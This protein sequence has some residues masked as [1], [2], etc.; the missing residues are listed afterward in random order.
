MRKG[1]TISG[2][3]CP[4]KNMM[5]YAKRT[6]VRRQRD[7]TLS[8]ADLA[9]QTIERVRDRKQSQLSKE[10]SATLEELLSADTSYTAPSGSVEAY[11][12]PSLELGGACCM[13]HAHRLPSFD[14]TSSDR[15]PVQT[16]PL[17]RCIHFG[18]VE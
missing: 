5:E 9:R 12:G 14:A 1:Q 7:E 10:V 13:R 16:V 4:N 6:R 17:R 3:R 8:T 11:S 2:S 18:Q 15:R